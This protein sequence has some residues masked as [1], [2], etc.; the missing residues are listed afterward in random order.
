LVLL[1]SDR[2]SLWAA[3]LVSRS[4]RLDNKHR[5]LPRPDATKSATLCRSR[6]GKL[7]RLRLVFGRRGVSCF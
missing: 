4:P 5:T 1:L 3:G 7:Q 6:S 2:F